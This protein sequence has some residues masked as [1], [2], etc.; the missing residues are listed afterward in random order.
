MKKIPLLDLRRGFQEIEEDIFRGFK[1]VFRS[2]RVLNGPNVEALEREWA[3][4]LGVKY[5]FGCSCGTSALIMALIAVGIKRGDEVLVQANAFIADFEAIYF[6]GAEPIFLDIDPTNFGPDLDDLKHKITPQTKALILV[7]MYGYPC[8]MDDILE[9][10]QKHN[11]ILIEDASHAHGAEYKGKKVGSF[12]KVGCFSCGPVKNF[13]AIGDAGMVVT[14]DEKIAFKLRYLRVHGQVEK[15]HS[16][17]PGFN[18]RLDELQAVILRAR[19]KS[20]DQKNEKRREIA[21]YYTENL[22]GI[23]DLYLPP[24]DPPYRKSVYHRYMIGSSQREKLVNFLRE[25]GIE[26]GYY[27]PIPLHQQKAYLD[28]FNK[29]WHLPTAEKLSKELLAI[30]IYPELTSEE[31]E[32]IVSTIREFFN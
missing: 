17:F 24:L 15:N 14:N 25:K 28:L 1:E 21:Q 19:L 16:H 11:I 3:E 23:G 31:I 10:C 5:A 8:E 6:V 29:R 12:G 26:T 32:Y 13:N 9:V 27:Y 18:S 7:H 30:P 20:L 4:Y 22:R 2:M